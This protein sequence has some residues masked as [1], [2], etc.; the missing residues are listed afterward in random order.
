MRRFAFLP[1]LIP[2]VASAQTT[3]EIPQA[4]PVPAPPLPS[5]S[6]APEQRPGLFFRVGFQRGASTLVEQYAGEY[7]FELGIGKYLNPTGLLGPKSSAAVELNYTLH[8]RRGTFDRVS[9][10]FSERVMLAERYESTG[11][12][13]GYALGM[14]Q[15]RLEGR[16]T[17]GVRFNESQTQALGRLIFGYQLNRRSAIEAAYTFTSRLKAVNVDGFGLT[18]VFR[19]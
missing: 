7:G 15:T 9:A 3:S 4:T 11:L 16:N 12:Y 17:A 2:V 14:G 19:F 8:N 13:A 6:V 1:L 5:I 18:Y 10:F